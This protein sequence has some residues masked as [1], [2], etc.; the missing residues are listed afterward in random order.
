MMGKR[1]LM[2]TALTLS[3]AGCQPAPPSYVENANALIAKQISAI[4]PQAAQCKFAQ[5]GDY[6]ISACSLGNARDAPVFAL[7]EQEGVMQANDNLAIA[8]VPLNEQARH[9]VRDPRFT[10]PVMQRRIPVDADQAFNRLFAQP[11]R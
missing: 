1:T 3:L 5:D 6:W 7:F 11:S 4:G 10:I 8:V 9:F 2:L